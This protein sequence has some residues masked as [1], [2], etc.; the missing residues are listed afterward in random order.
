MDTIGLSLQERDRRYKLIRRKMEERGLDHLLIWGDSGKW[1]SKMANIRYVSQI[2]GNGEE[3][4]AVFSRQGDPTVIIWGSP[5]M[6]EEWLSSQSWVC[7]VRSRKGTWS[8]LALS[9]LKEKG[10]D[11]GN[12]GVVGLQGRSPEG[13]IPYVTYHN[14]LEGLPNVHFE[15]ATDILE[16]IRMIKSEEELRC[17][18]KSQEISD[19]AVPVLHEMAKE[20]VKES[21]IYAR[22]VQ[23]ML[24]NGSETPVMFLW[25][26]GDHRRALR[27]MFARQRTLERG[28][29]ILTE[30]GGRYCGYY[31]HAS[32]PAIVGVPRE[33]YGKLLGVSIECYYSATAVL[34]P[35]ITA[36]E[37]AK[38]CLEPIRKAGLDRYTGVLFHGIGLGWESPL[39]HMRP[40]VEREPMVMQE[41]MVLALENG[42]AIPGGKKGTHLGDPVVVT[43]DG[44]RS[45]SK[46][47][48]EWGLKL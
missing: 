29:V 45:L 11:T 22:M 33:P 42:A 36:G 24:A 6:Q 40:D 27:L 9:L 7:D 20:G 12:V 8:S 1:D 28:D 34:K 17:I 30:Y 25:S 13:D 16:D 44:C 47:K 3:A 37:L 35:G 26:A 15:N 31:G 46:L 38:A 48:V 32:R 14:I 41:G 5:A 21:E 39:G 4:I 2:G 19:L 23:T 10:L 18:E 43:K